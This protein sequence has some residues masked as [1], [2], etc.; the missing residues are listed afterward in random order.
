L[1]VLKVTA[2]V[3]FHRPVRVK[4]VAVLRVVF[5]VVL[6][7]VKEIQN[8]ILLY[9]ILK[10][11]YSAPLLLVHNSF[12][13][14]FAQHSNMAAG[15]SG[16]SLFLWKITKNTLYGLLLVRSLAGNYIY[17]NILRSSFS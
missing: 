14:A 1:A 8:Y 16:K 15:S 6:P 3:R 13:V 2:T 17:I 9:I 5:L 10:E 12:A 4:E 11:L 7:T